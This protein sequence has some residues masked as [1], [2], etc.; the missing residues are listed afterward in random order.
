MSYLDNNATTKVAPEVCDVILDCLKKD[1]GNPS[2]LHK[3]GQASANLLAEARERVASSINAYPDEIIFVGSGSEANNLCI[4]GFCDFHADKRKHIITSSIEHPSVLEVYR[5]LEAKGFEVT[6]LP[7]NTEGFIALDEIEKAIRP[8]TFLVSLMHANNE[9]GTIQPI[10]KISQMCRRQNV[11]FHTDAVQSFLKVPLDVQKIPIDLAS[12]SGHKIHGPKGI[13]FV[14]KRRGLSITSQVNGGGQEMKLRAGT[15]NLA[16]ILGLAKA[17]GIFDIKKDVMQMRK[18]QSHA[19][20]KLLSMPN[21]RLNGP[22]DLV[23]RICNNINISVSHV[24]GEFLLEQLSQS[25]IFVST[26]S[27]CSS[28]STKVSPVL[29]AINCPPEYIHGNIRI[30]LSRYTTMKDVNNFIKEF[31]RI[32]SG[33]GNG[34]NITIYGN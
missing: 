16:F 8:D 1:Y 33:K 28:K 23:K 15:E 19:I 29:R 12:F 30:S 18:L 31:E 17:I 11:I 25:N 24:E 5:V 32:V 9:I 3:L 6:Y 2:S 7:V 27:A 13:G 34:L 22:K 10:E 21:I 20:D 14:Y 26:G 4:K